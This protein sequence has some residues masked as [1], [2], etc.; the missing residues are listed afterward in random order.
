MSCLIFC[1]RKI[2]IDDIFYIVLNFLKNRYKKKTVDQ[3]KKRKSRNI[4]RGGV[5]YKDFCYKK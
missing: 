2:R 4:G 5:L 3:T 1:I